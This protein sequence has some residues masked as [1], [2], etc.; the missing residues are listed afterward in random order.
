MTHC[1][2]GLGSNLNSPKRQLHLALNALK[3]LPKTYILKI[4]PFYQTA[5]LGVV[6]QPMYCNAVVLLETCLTPEQI[7]SYVQA[8]ETH[9]K[10]VR[11][12]RWGSRTLDID[13]LLYGT[14]CSTIPSLIIPHPRLHERAFMLIPLLDIWPDATLPDGTSLKTCL[15]NLNTQQLRD[16]A[17]SH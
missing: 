3:T 17:L 2:L 6:G 13:V 9:Q 4:S 5:P 12:K 7:L 14:H 8:I 1:Y 15:Q 16:V 10:R 11:K